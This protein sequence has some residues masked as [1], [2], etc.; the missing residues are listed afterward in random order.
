VEIRITY[1]IKEHIKFKIDVLEVASTIF[2]ESKSL[3][4]YEGTNELNLYPRAFKISK[5]LMN[6]WN[7][8][9]DGFKA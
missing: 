5:A 8:F 4:D 6:F 2:H 3:I 7:A 9:I 1:L